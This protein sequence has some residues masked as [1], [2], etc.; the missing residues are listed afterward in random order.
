MD[1][2]GIHFIDDFDLNEEATILIRVDFNVPLEDGKVT[3]ETRIRAAIPTIAHAIESGA[4]VI[5]CSHLG[6]PKG[7]RTPELSLEPVAAR[8]AEVIDTDTLIYDME[9]VFP[10]NVVGDDVDTLLTE[11]NPKRQLMLLENL[12]FEPGEKAGDDE[13][14][15]RLAALAD[16]YIN[17]AFGAAHRKHASVY[18]INKF[19][20]RHHRGAGFLIRDE[21][22]GLGRLLDHPASPYVAIVGG[23]KVSDKLGVLR[24]LIDRVDTILV[25]GAMAYTFLAADGV[26]V[27]D[28]LVEADY[29]DEARSILERT[30]MQKTELILPLD[31]GIGDGI[32]AARAEVTAD[33]AIPEGK[34]GLDIGPKT[35]ARFREIIESAATIFW[36]GPLGVFENEAFA[37]GT[38]AIARAVAECEAYS[39]IGGGDSAAAVAR[40]GVADDIGHVSTGGGASLQLVEGKPLPGVESLRPNYPFD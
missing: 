3:D 6:R 2:T 37:E 40:A 27:G 33:A 36:N 34:M 5:L 19:F 4:K 17:D 22:E 38:M 10:E 15:K 35:R 25:G 9:V 1:T 32:D 31:H 13:F 29:V 11:L 8:L 24:A 20:D 16:V 23:A 28:S 30:K 18:T 21:L 7:E 39:V 26:E 12:R 14:A